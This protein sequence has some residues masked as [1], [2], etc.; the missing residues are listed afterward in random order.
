[1]IRVLHLVSSLSTN[2]GVMSVIMN[3]YRHINR[4]KIQFDFC[5]FIERNETYED[6]IKSMGGHIYLISKPSITNVFNNDLKLFF[7]QN[8]GIYDILHIHEP[9]LTFLFAPIA[10][11]Y[12]IGNIITHAHN[13]KYSDKKI[14]AIRNGIACIPL[15]RQ[16]NHYFACSEAAGKFLYGEKAISD[17]KVTVIN[18]AIDC[19]KFKYNED[20]RNVV[21]KELGLEDNFIIGHVGRFIEQ[22][23]HTF[24]IDIFKAIKQRKKNAKLILIGDGELKNKILWKAEQLN[25]ENDVLFLG[26]RD[27]VHRL[28]QAMDVFVLPSLF[29]GLPVI[30]VE[31]QAS[32]L[33]IV[34]S[35]NIT[36]EIGLVNYSYIGLEE[37]A[38]YWAEHIISIKHRD[39]RNAYM[40]IMESGFDI[41][42]EAKKLE[43]I[44]SDMNC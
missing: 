18:N 23:N 22:K 25:L 28:M 3:Y 27:D 14:N 31:V 10:K 36:R 12:G 42:E 17:G 4:E 30:G 13:T 33:P 37:P 21:R 40:R 38:D 39:R 32:G 19:C 43:K 7:R 1:M 29:E 26:I 44:Y 8:Q 35:K 24:L 6:E 2:S 20:V 41:H 11:K 5:Y 34:M 9:H 15:K 16:A